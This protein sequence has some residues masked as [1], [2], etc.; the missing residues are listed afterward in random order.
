MFSLWEVEVSLGGDPRIPRAISLRGGS[1]S[2]NQ[3]RQ[4]CDTRAPPAP[5]HTRLANL[6]PGGCRYV[7][8][9]LSKDTRGREW[10]SLPKGTRNG[11][12]RET[13]LTPHAPGFTCP[14][15]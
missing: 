9:P 6:Q 1:A 13:H 4:P 14:R 10:A 8:I 5:G 11:G 7:S 2:Q 12:V 3:L 15:C